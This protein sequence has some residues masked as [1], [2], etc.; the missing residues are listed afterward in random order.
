MVWLRINFIFLSFYF[1]LI[2]IASSDANVFASP[3]WTTFLDQLQN[4]ITLTCVEP[5]PITSCGTGKFIL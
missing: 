4:I 3:D 2:I 5:D 1:N